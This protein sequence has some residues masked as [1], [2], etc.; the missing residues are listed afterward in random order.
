[1]KA[2][3]DFETAVTLYNLRDGDVIPLKTRVFDSRLVIV[4]LK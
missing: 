3:G 4:P 1:M 2:L